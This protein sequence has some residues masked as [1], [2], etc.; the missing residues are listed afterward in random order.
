M[1][2]NRRDD[3]LFEAHVVLDS[4]LPSGSAAPSRAESVRPRGRSPPQPPAPASSPHVLLHASTRDRPRIT[5]SSGAQ[6][7]RRAAAL[8]M[9]FFTSSAARSAALPAMNVTRL[10]YEPEIDRRQVGVGRNH[11]HARQAAAQHLGNHLRRHGV[12]TL[13]NLRRSG[14]H[15]HAAVAIDLDVDRRVRHVRANDAVGRSAHVVTA[16]HA[17]PAA[18][19]QLAAPFTPSRSRHDLVHALRQSIAQHAQA[20]HRHR[21]RLE[22]ITCAASVA[23]STP[24]FA[25]I[26]SICDSNANRTFTVPCPRIAPQAGLL[27]STR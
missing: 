23:G 22:Q 20:V 1:N 19:R 7:M 21:R 4:L 25:A 18:L 11:L 16:R 13:P 24:I 26:S 3:C 27:V 6:F 10:E 2:I 14:V 15:H 17:Q 5:T 8:T 9:F 12:G